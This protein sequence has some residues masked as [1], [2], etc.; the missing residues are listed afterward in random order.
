MTIEQFDDLKKWFETYVDNVT[1]DDNRLKTLIT[2]KYNH[3]HEVAV[4]CRGIAEDA[5]MSA[6]DILTA[7]LLGLFHDI[8]RFS[9][10][11]EFQTF[12]DPDSLNHGEH[13]YEIAIKTDVLSAVSD[14]D[15]QRILNGIRYHNSRIIPEHLDSDV[16]PFVKLIRDAD[17]LDI[18]RV[19]SETLGNK[20]FD[21]YPEITLHIDID[22]P[23]NPA[24]LSQVRRLETVSYENVKSLL[25]FRLTQLAWIFDINYPFTFRQII[26][27]GF[28]NEITGSLPEDDDIREVI[29]SVVDF[30]D[31]KLKSA[32]N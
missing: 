12:S 14:S 4:N 17:K 31:S 19:I 9:Q 13:G 11:V 1:P 3:S 21:K 2:L 8:G 29:R 27:R 16:L 18:F 22:G 24:A 23:V 25:D 28:L 32:V 5:N 26:E 30:I 15:K 20:D 7:E 10:L 6:S